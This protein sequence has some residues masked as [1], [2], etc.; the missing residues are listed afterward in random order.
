MAFLRMLPSGNEN[1]ERESNPIPKPLYMYLFRS[2]L[3]P[4]LTP[5]N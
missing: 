3:L 5:P 4:N 1:P 2:A